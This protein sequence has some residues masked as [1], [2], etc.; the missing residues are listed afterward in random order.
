MTQYDRI[1]LGRQAKELADAQGRRIRCEIKNNAVPLPRRQHRFDGALFGSCGIAE[2]I[3]KDDGDKSIRVNVDYRSERVDYSKHG[4]GY[5]H[6]GSGQTVRRDEIRDARDQLKQ[7][8]YEVGVFA[9]YAA[10]GIVLFVG[11]EMLFMLL[12][13]ENNE[14]MQEFLGFI[15]NGNHYFFSLGIIAVSAPVIALLWMASVKLFERR[16]L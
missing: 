14:N 10:V 4:L 12:S 16:E 8:L 7:L 13:D 3:G 11:V 1:T 2:D 9:L 6:N 5:I 15:A